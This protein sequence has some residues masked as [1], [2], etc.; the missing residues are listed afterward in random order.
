MRAEDIDDDEIKAITGL[1][2]FLLGR[3]GW[4]T[5]KD[6]TPGNLE[7][8]DLQFLTADINVSEP[9]LLLMLRYIEPKVSFTK[10]FGVALLS[11]GLTA[12]A[13]GGSAISTTTLRS[14]PYSQAFLI[15][16]ENGELIWKNHALMIDRKSAD[17]NSLFKGFPYRPASKID[18]SAG[19]SSGNN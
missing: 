5:E 6:G 16:L 10:A 19:I 13:T 12:A 4:V 11:A 9:S 14:D 3:V 15:N 1:Y 8:L 7:R 2:E 18:S 17:R